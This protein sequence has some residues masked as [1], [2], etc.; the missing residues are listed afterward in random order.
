MPDSRRIPPDTLVAI[1]PDGTIGTEHGT[2]V[3]PFTQS[4]RRPRRATS[5]ALL[6]PVNLLIVGCD[7]D[8]VTDA[9][10]TRGWRRPDDGAVHVIWSGGRRL[11]MSDHTALGNRAERVHVRLFAVAGHTVAAA[12]HEVAD[13]RGHHVVTSWD[14]ARA[15]VANALVALGYVQLPSSAELLPIDLRGVD[16]DGHIW[17]IRPPRD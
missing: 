2:R 14:R 17:R 4:R 5:P 15:A 12:H 11:L 16:G 1:G 8:R 3:W 10:A 7:P 13:A 6:D 9:L